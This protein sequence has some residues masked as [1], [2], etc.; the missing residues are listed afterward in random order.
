MELYALKVN[1]LDRPLG[2]FLPRTVFSWKVRQANGFCQQAARLVIRREAADGQVLHD[3]GFVQKADSLGWKI[4]LPLQP[5]TRYVWQL[6]VRDDTGGEACAESWFET[7]KRDEPFA[8]K[9]IGCKD[10]EPRH[11]IFEKQVQPRPGLVCARL[12]ITGLGLYEAYYNGKKIGDEYLTPGCTNYDAW[13]QVQTYDVTHLLTQEG[14]LSVMLGNG[15]YKGR[16]GMDG[17]SGGVYGDEWKLLAELRLRYEDGGEEVLG[18]DES[19]RMRRSKITFSNFY[20]GEHRDDTLPEC[21]EEPVKLV[22]PPKG[23]LQDRMSPPV[24]VYKRLQPVE[25]L[26]TPKG[27]TVLDLG[28]EITG[29]FALRVEQPAGTVIHIQCGE[30]LQQGNFYN[31][32][33][34]SARAE[35][36]YKSSGAPVVLRPHFT[37]YGYR[38]VKIEGVPDLKKEDFTAL[39][40]STEMDETGTVS[41]GHPLVNKLLSNIRWGMRDNFVDLPT[42]CPQRDERMGWTGDAQ[43]FLPTACC[44]AYSDACY[45]KYLHDLRT[46]QDSRQGLVPNV[47]PSFGAQRCSSVWGDA[48]CLMPWALYQIYGDAS[49][50]ED[51][52][53]SMKAWVDAIR[54]LDGDAHG[55]RKAFHFGDW[56]ALDRPGAGPDSTMGCTDEGFIADVY[57]YH[58]TDL[59]ARAAQILGKPEDAAFYASEAERLRKEIEYEYYTGSGRCC[60]RTQTA[61]LLTL[62]FGLS[63]APERILQTLCQLLQESGN[64]L[65][66][67][68]VGTPLLCNTLSENGCGELACQLLLNEETPGWLYAVKLGA[69]TIWE[70][71][72]SVLSDGTINPSGM[73]SLNHYAYGS[74]GEWLFRHLAGLDLFQTPG[75][76]HGKLQPTLCWNIKHANARFDSPAGLWECGWEILDAGHVKVAVTVPFGCTAELLLPLADLASVQASG[77]NPPALCKATGGAS[78]YL[79]AGTYVFYYTTVRLLKKIYS[80]RDS[81]AELSEKPNVWNKLLEVLPLD[82]IPKAYW[83]CTVRQV[84]G[85]FGG[86]MGEQQLDGLDR[87][88]A[89]LSEE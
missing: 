70:R 75:C 13:V 33:L 11:P 66:T 60:F 68:F 7:G 52:Y 23:I 54:R 76:R 36:L 9:W 37:D 78:C 64:K 58:S 53:P 51:Q 56:L 61:M 84:A 65:Q 19:W 82:K 80:T 38:Y 62:H 74:V 31:D 89:A 85:Q 25:L 4:D 67:G 28:Q 21:P 18:T 39:A 3:T 22:Q 2:H 44:L 69:T 57:Y 8:A 48:A 17:R 72:N 88:L 83:G 45:A 59:V 10:E 5:R 73:N 27:E 86:R 49:I 24:T 20:D 14:T 87:L 71:W 41:T 29:I 40:L 6:T 16:F 15:W 47:V 30:F 42:D 43:V 12:Y 81:L 79:Q 50:L 63:S 46:E 55:W 32:N 77:D 1:H 34:R 26:H 35:Y